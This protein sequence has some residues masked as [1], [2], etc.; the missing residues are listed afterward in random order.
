MRVM[1]IGAGGQLGSDLVEG[2]RERKDEVTALARNELDIT[3]PSALR[4]MLAR[5]RPDVVMNCSVYHPV[6]ECEAHPDRSFAVNATAIRDLGLAARESEAAVVHFSSDYV[7]DG[8]QGRPYGEEDTP[9]PLSVFGVCKLAGE[10]LLRAVCHCHFIIRTSGLYGLAGSRAKRGNFVETMLRLGAR[11]GRVRVVND[12]RMAQTY[13]R[14]VARQTLAL[15]RTQHYGTYHASDHGDYSWYEFAQR[16]F[17]YA[18]MNVEVT[19]VSWHAMPSVATRPRYS[20]LE[21]RRLKALGMDQMEPIDIAL[22]AYL[23]A[24]ESVPA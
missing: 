3:E 20:V 10:H 23:R 2:L 1:V 13:T 16:I 21:N 15:I 24:R 5:H 14:N 12:L 9:N 6:D 19:P 4:E 17:K 18:A 7:F 22:Q 11:E 8:E